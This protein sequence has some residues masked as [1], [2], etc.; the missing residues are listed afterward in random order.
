MTPQPPPLPPAKKSN[1]LMWVLIGIGGFVVFC[2]LA[3]GVGSYF[4]YRTVKN[5]GFDT[6]LMRTNPGLAL[7]KLATTLHPDFDVV[8][9]N[10]RAGTITMR[11]KSTGK[12]MTMKWDPANSS[13]V[14][15][16]DDGQEVKITANGTGDNSEVKISG[17]SGEMKFSAKGSGTG[18]SWVPVYPGSTPAGIASVEVAD[19][20][21]STSTFKTKDPPSKVIPYFQAELFTKGFMVNRVVV[22]GEGGLLTAQD[23]AKKR[24]MTLIASS[25]EGETEVSITAVEKK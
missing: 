18:P 12:V 15:L 10:E 21:Q 2:V 14:M 6:E 7:T 11:E 3:A 23:D 22:N 19:A 20:Y 9:T 1:V 24:T 8:T 13:L 25:A 17:S 4:L 16:A 5:A